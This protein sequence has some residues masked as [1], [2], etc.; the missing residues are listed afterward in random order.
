M[1]TLLLDLDSVEGQLSAFTKRMVER[2]EVSMEYGGS[3]RNPLT[4]AVLE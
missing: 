2:Q 1:A 4:L 3:P